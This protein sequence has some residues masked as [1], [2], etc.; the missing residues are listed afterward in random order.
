MRRELHI[1]LS[2]ELFNATRTSNLG[3]TCNTR[4]AAQSVSFLSEAPL[5][6]VQIDRAR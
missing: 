1:D 5:E 4:E 3:G 6:L 2:D